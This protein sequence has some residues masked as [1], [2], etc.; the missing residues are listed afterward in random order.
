MEDPGKRKYPRI[1]CSF[2]AEGTAPKPFGDVVRNVSR[3]GCFVETDENLKI[4]DRYELVI[5]VPY[6]SVPS[7]RVGEVVWELKGRGDEETDALIRGFGVKFLDDNPDD[8]AE[9]IDTIMHYKVL[10]SLK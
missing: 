10:K 3:G 5:H 1:T 7:V 8:A 6:K 4:G 2:D 9:L